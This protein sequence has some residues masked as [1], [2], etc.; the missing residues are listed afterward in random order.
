VAEGAKAKP[1]G[2]AGLDRVPAS[3]RR[4]FFRE[5]PRECVL[6]F[7]TDRESVEPE[8]VYPRLF[9]TMLD[10]QAAVA[11]DYRPHVWSTWQDGVVTPAIHR[12]AQSSRRSWILSVSVARRARTNEISSAASPSDMLEDWAGP[13][14]ND[15][16]WRSDTG[17]K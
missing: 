1:H 10:L 7:G 6:K 12:T 9:V 16:S 4:A 3:S 17:A 15:C 11:V 8:D 14:S 2:L 5:P 13:D